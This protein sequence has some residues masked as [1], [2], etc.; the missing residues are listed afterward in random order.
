MGEI[1]KKERLKNWKQNKKSQV[2]RKKLEQGWLHGY[3]SRV[4][5]GRG[6]EKKIFMYLG[7]S[8]NAKTD[9]T[10]QKSANHQTN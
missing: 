4:R 2:E 3:P 5:A 1:R 9:R 10:I 6:S 7:R 8:S